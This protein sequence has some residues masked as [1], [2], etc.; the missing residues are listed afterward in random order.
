VSKE[1]VNF[2]VGCV[3]TSMGSAGSLPVVKGL[4]MVLAV[5]RRAVGRDIS[6][7]VSTTFRNLIAFFG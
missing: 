3:A 2:F 4:P 1:P 7:R 6:H 5:A